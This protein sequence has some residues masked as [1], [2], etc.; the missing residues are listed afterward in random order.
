MINEGLD[1]KFRNEYNLNKMAAQDWIVSEE[2][3]TIQH[4]FSCIVSLHE[5]VIM[6]KKINHLHM[7]FHMPVK[8]NQFIKFF[9][10]SRCNLLAADFRICGVSLIKMRPIHELAID[11]HTFFTF[12]LK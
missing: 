7:I 4:F 5:P 11:L 12:S 3:R 10:N 2:L 8:Q 6:N 1:G 9:G